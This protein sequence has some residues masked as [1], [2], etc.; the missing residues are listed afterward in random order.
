MSDP[1]MN[2]PRC[3]EQCACRATR[4]DLNS[5]LT[6]IEELLKGG[7]HEGPCTNVDDPF[8][9]CELHVEASRAREDRA[10]EFLKTTPKT[11]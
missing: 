2:C 7:E 4:T 3:G 5:A 1:S 10:R 8:D 9:S 6:V 11:E